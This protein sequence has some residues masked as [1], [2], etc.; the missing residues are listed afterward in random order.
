MKKG[1]Y[2]HLTASLLGV[3]LGMLLQWTVTKNS[4]NR[5]EIKGKIK[6][7]NTTDS[8]QNVKNN[9]QLR[10]QKR[11]TK[12]QLKKAQRKQKKSTN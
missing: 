3:I 7:K 11:I 9:F 8:I 6:Q 5:T 1:F 10:K 2:T 4:V 12:R